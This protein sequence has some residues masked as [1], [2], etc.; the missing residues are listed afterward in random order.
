ML[1]LYIYAEKLL[2]LP[3][4]IRKFRSYNK[5]AACSITDLTG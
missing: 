3:F 4:E 5:D 1:I 2:V